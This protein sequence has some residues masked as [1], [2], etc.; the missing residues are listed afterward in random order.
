MN[1]KY[2]GF[3][4]NGQFYTAKNYLREYKE[5]KNQGYLR[6]IKNR[7]KVFEHP[8]EKIVEM[9]KSQNV[10]MRRLGIRM[11]EGLLGYE[12]NNDYLKEE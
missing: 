5:R 3:L 12:P 8:S 11:A 4:I 7:L 10:E 2:K 1:N 9:L 6:F